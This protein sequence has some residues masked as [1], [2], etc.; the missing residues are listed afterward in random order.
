ME[1]TE[2]QPIHGDK[3]RIPGIVTVVLGVGIAV[4]GL[5]GNFLLVPGDLVV[6]GVGAALWTWLRTPRQY[7]VYADS[8]VIE[9]GRPRVRIIPFENI[10]R[11]E[12]HTLA[13]PDRLRV[14]LKNGRRIKLVLRNPETFYEELDKAM[15]AYF[16]VHPELA[17]EYDA[18]PLEQSSPAAE[19]PPIV[20]D[21]PPAAVEDANSETPP[22]EDRGSQS[23]Y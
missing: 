19:L 3:H 7:L 12:M 4:W 1:Q 11:L 18:P 9:Y 21:P 20:A 16:R 23:P 8:L 22:E 2:N 5:T 13:I 10:S 15:A 17:S 6:L 14:F